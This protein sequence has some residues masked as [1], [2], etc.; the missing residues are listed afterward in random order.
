MRSG[1]F[2]LALCTLGANAFVIPR[3]DIVLTSAANDS[4][5]TNWTYVGCYK[6]VEVHLKVLELALII[7]PLVTPKFRGP[8]AG[9]A[10]TLPTP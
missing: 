1:L 3:D 9:L 2:T 5:P 6:Y 8:S 10:L 4:L 7:A